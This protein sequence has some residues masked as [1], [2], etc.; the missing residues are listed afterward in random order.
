MEALFQQSVSILFVVEE[1]NDKLPQSARDERKKQMQSRD[2]KLSPY[3][4][5]PETEKQISP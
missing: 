3:Q 5:Y 1:A 4:G 2:T